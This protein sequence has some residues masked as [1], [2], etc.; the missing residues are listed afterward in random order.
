MNIDFQEILKELEF[1]VPI[2]IIDLTQE[3]QVTEL[4]K[5]L[6]ENGVVNANEYAQRARVIFGYVNEATKQP[7]I[8]SLLNKTVK[9]TETGNDIKVSSALT[10][11]KSKSPGQKGAYTAAVAMLKKSG[12]SSKDITSLQ[13]KSKSTEPKKAEPTKITAT[14][15]QSAAETEKVKKSADATHSKI[16]GKPSGKVMGDEKEADN[17]VKNNMLKYGFTGYK[18]KTGKDPAPGSAGSAFNEIV[19]GEGVKILE[20]N[21][22]LNEEELTRVITKQFCGTALGKEQ[23]V[24][25]NVVR[26]LPDD[27]KKND[28]ASKALIAARSARAKYDIIQTDLQNLQTDGKFSKNTKVHAFYGAKESLEAQVDVL[29]KS[30]GKIYAA[31]GAELDRDDAI[32]FVLAGG[33]GWNPSDTASFVTDDKGN[34]MIEFFSDKTSPADIQ[35]NSTLQYEIDKKKEQIN[36]LENNK[37]ISKK[38]ADAARLAVDVHTENISKLENS[39]SEGPQIVADNFNKYAKKAG[40]SDKD[41]LDALNGKKTLKDKT[42]LKNFEVAVMDK[43]G[44]K[45]EILENLPKGCDKNKP[46]Q[47]CLYFALRSVVA[48]GE[49]TTGQQKVINKISSIL[50]KEFAIKGESAPEGIDVNNI[51]GVQRKKIVKSHHDFISN[52]DKIKI[53]YEGSKIGLGTLTHCDDVIDSFHLSLMDGKPY[54]KGDPSSILS[55]SFNVIMG[56]P[57]VN[58]EILRGC[59]GVSNTKEFR[60]NFSVQNVAEYTYEYNEK[61]A[62]EFLKRNGNTNPKPKDIEIARNVTGIKLFSYKIN[63]KTGEKEEIGFR[64]YRGKA[65]KTSKT[66]TTMQY[67]NKMQDCIKSKSKSK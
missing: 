25:S 15:F 6:R 10:Y 30:K 3:S 24:S 36:Y 28:C 22:K 17:G 65:G 47:K 27:L 19:S 53:D 13:N 49:S 8:K 60:K 14:Q 61:Q 64:T 31:D 21:P 58:G 66:S 62:I 39:L 29:K 9:N 2:G 4:V 32:A 26:D 43:K 18:S 33:G 56:G 37:I 44:I 48:K 11:A 23:S 20:K 50:M 63:K 38:Q 59:L 45:K 35:D 54:K 1:R 57:K 5:I 40:V 34:V 16:Y 41:Q 12:V 52:M 55:H 51:A 67:S 7:D 46:D 42:L